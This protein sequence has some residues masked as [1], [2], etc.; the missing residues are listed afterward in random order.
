MNSAS[1]LPLPRL[2]LSAL[3][4]CAMPTGAAPGTPPKVD[5]KRF[6]GTWYE[7][8]RLPNSDFQSACATDRGRSPKPRER[9]YQVY[10]R[11]NS[12]A[13]PK[14]PN[15]GTE[16]VGAGSEMPGK[17]LVAAVGFELCEPLPSS[18]ST[19]NS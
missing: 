3:L 5:V 16:D 10:Q 18:R 1:A 19:A 7:L 14:R 12:G 11:G 2:L 15:P 6:A 9:A 4:A 17:D 13:M 8:A